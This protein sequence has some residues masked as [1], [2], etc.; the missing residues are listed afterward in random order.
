[1][2]WFRKHSEGINGKIAFFDAPFYK[3][4][5]CSW[6][7]L[8]PASMLVHFVAYSSSHPIAGDRWT[9]ICD[10]QCI[11]ACWYLRHMMSPATF[12][13][14][15]MSPAIF[16]WT[17]RKYR[18]LLSICTCMSPETY[19]ILWNHCNTRWL[20]FSWVALT[21]EFTPSTKTNYKR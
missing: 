16:K 19:G 14:W 18:K 15:D 13:I 9:E 2:S 3:M 6:H 12:V 7:M 8:S 17:S 11:N 4:C 20:S 5:K 1:M 21:Q 10:I